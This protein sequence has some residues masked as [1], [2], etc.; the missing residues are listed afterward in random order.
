MMENR[1]LV[2]FCLFTFSLFF[3]ID[4]VWS[5]DTIYLNN[6]SFEDVPRKGTPF[7]PPIKGW[8]DCG[9]S[10]FS[11][12]S[13]PDIHPVPGYAWNVAMRPFEGNTYLGLVI[14]YNETYESVSQ[15]LS[16]PLKAGKCYSVSAAL[17]LAV[18]YQSRTNRSKDYVESFSFPSIL[19]IW[20]GNE[21][22]STKELLVQSEP[23]ENLNWKRFEFLLR[24][25][26]DYKYLTLEAFYVDE[27][28]EKYNGH[29][30]LDGLSPIVEVE[31]K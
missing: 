24:P 23:I 19:R 20:G 5:Q 27:L 1:H 9:I 28:S 13:P 3:L 17:T 18:T 11:S 31:C 14:R 26:Q 29:L 2:T 22:C 4:S 25:S 16:I 6:P 10:K 30:L 12:E 21:F 8:H 15:A 7:S